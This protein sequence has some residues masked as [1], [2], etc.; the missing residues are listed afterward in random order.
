M[1]GLA[2]RLGLRMVKG[3]ANADGAR[4]VAARGEQAY[5]LRR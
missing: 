2:V 4:I 1:A 5:S 3:L